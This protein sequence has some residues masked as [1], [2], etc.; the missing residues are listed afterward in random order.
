MNQKNIEKLG[1][2]VGYYEKR[3][4]HDQ[5]AKAEKRGY[6]RCMEEY[7]LYTPMHGSE[8]ER[9]YTAG[10]KDGQIDGYNQAIEDLKETTYGRPWKKHRHPEFDLGDD[11]V[12]EDDDCGWSQ[13]REMIV[14]IIE[15]LKKKQQ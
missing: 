15:Q 13:K 11:R 14:N 10:L 8:A 7:D 9:W 1:D 3:I 5:I 12:C 4:L 2:S 6:E